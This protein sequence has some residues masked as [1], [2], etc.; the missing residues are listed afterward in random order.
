MLATSLGGHALFLAGEWVAASVGLGV[1]M[2]VAMGGVIGLGAFV[3][4]HMPSVDVSEDSSE[5]VEVADQ[6]AGK[7]ST[8]PDD[9]H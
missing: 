7:Q 6:D 4:A 5:H 9:L 1:V 2:A 3:V 8:S